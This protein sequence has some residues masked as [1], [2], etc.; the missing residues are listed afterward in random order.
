MNT[1]R[2]PLSRDATVSA[3]SFPNAQASRTET[4]QRLGGE[5]SCLHGDGE[6]STVNFPMAAPPPSTHHVLGNL[7]GRWQ[8]PVFPP[9]TP[10]FSAALPCSRHPAWRSCRQ[11]ALPSRLPTDK[12]GG[13]SITSANQNGRLSA[14]IS[15]FPTRG[16]M[17]CHRAQHLPCAP[18][19]LSTQHFLLHCEL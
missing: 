3:I 19:S 1:F 14:S 17:Q 4:R 11:L 5:A 9:T 12:L 15:G 2:L 13:N 16:R 10:T 7:G 6:L 8:P 18:A